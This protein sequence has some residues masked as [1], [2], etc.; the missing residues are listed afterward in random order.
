MNVEQIKQT[1]ARPET[2]RA[3]A[4]FLIIGLSAGCAAYQMLLRCKVF[5]LVRQQIVGQQLLLHILKTQTG[6]SIR[7]T[8]AGD[9]LVTEEQDCL[10]DDVQDFV[11]IGEDLIQVTSLCNT[12]APSAADINTV[13]VGV[14]GEALERALVDAASAVV[15]YILIDDNLAIDN[16]CSL[17]RAVV[18]NLADLA[19]AALLII[20][21]RYTLADNAEVV[22]VGLDTVVRAAADC[23]LELV[24]QF[25]SAVA[26]KEPFV[27]L[28]RQREGV[29]QTILA[30]R[31]LT[32][33]NRTYFGTGTRRSPV[34]LLQGMHAEARC[35]HTERPEFQQSD[36]WSLRFRRC[37]RWRLLRK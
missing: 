20:N 2:G 17:N 19:S 5:F 34:L 9:A 36:G 7:E 3:S 31:T 33:N 25:N 37:R 8:F 21:L 14:V 1:D 15:T 13:A 16:A 28:F 12:F 24:R 30:G 10:L 35:S 11:T 26:F 22:Q 6:N 29:N 4:V 23:D 18:D 32:G 27:N